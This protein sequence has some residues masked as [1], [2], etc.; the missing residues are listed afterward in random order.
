MEELEDSKRITYHFTTPDGAHYSYAVPMTE[1]D[2]VDHS[3]G[4]YPE[5]TRLSFH[6][7]DHCQW[8]QTDFC[9]VAVD[10][11]GPVGILGKFK[12]FETMD[13]VVET[14][15]RTYSKT[16]S[17]QEGLSGLLGLVMARSA[18]PTFRVFRGAAWFHLPF[19][20][21]EETMFRITGTYLLRKFLSEGSVAQSREQIIDEIQAVYEEVGHSN[22][23]II[24]RMRAG[25]EAESDA[26]YNAIT[27]L[28]SMGCMVSL[29]IESGLGEI[30]KHFI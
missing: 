16:T 8:K 23:R 9:P 6:Q 29:S 28:D 13:A 11:R 12:S 2:I 20:S 7:C 18:C 19:A 25:L 27:I 4:D 24:A 21:M 10:L 14:A 22:R 30:R 5:W 3:A 1:R 15:E 26:N 17:I